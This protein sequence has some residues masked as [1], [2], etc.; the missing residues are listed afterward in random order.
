MVVLRSS[1]GSCAVRPLQTEA[2]VVM[3]APHAGVET[4][5]LAR[6]EAKEGALIGALVLVAGRLAVIVK[7]YS[8]E[9]VNVV[10]LDDLQP[11]TNVTG[12]VAHRPSFICPVFWRHPSGVQYVALVTGIN[13]DLQHDLLVLGDGY[14]DVGAGPGVP[15]AIAHVTH[16]AGH[17]GWQTELDP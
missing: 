5:M 4:E 6:R 11:L 7:T 1:H 10:R 8:P 9:L 15:L 13:A 12:F 14:F 2:V 16:G 3:N 17:L